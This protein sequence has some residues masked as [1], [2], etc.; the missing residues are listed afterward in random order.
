MLPEAYLLDQL[1]VQFQRLLPRR[2]ERHPLGCHRPRVDDLR[3]FTA[4][5]HMGRRGL[6]YREAEHD[7][8]VS[9]TTLRRRR[10]EWALALE[11]LHRV[12]LHAYDELVGL[13]LQMLIADS[14]ITKAPCGGEVSGPSPVDRGKLGLKVG[15]AC[16]QKGVPLAHHLTPANRSDTRVLEPL[17]AELRQV[18]H[19][20]TDARLYLDKGFDNGR[21]DR[22]VEQAGL[23]A[24]TVRKGDDY[25]RGR[26]HRWPV[27]RSNSWMHNYRKLLRMTERTEAGAR[28]F[29][30]LACAAITLQRLFAARPT[31]ADGRWI[32]C[33]RAAA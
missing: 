14:S 19:L 4:L 23:V 33:W 31:A 11:R 17:L 12:T 20:P 2:I 27:E 8:G 13:R 7:F 22:A 9:D 29:V 26:R 10:V 1:F 15:V 21:C 25:P 6:S 32:D 5:F 16:D 28:F 30:D 24:C 3:C 18:V